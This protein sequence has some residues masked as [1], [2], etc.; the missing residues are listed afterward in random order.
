MRQSNSLRPYFTLQEDVQICFY[1]GPFPDGRLDGV[2]HYKQA[3]MTQDRG[4][5]DPLVDAHVCMTRILS[6]EIDVNPERVSR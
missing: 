4:S 3:I 6:T 1:S 2:E 5:P